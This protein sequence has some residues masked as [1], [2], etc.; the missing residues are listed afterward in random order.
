MDFVLILVVLLN[1]KKH[2]AS[3]PYESGLLQD[4][5]MNSN[6]L[7]IYGDPALLVYTESPCKVHLLELAIW[8]QHFKNL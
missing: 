8:A 3:M 5:D 1:V 7:C 6:I 4:V 2:D